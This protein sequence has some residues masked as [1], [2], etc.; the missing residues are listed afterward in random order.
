MPWLNLSGFVH[1][2]AE[3]DCPFSSDLDPC[4]RGNGGCDHR[5]VNYGGRPVCQC[6]PGY[7]LLGDRRMCEGIHQILD[8]FMTDES[9]CPGSLDSLVE[10]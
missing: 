6:N 1:G 5:C 10:A 2:I 4:N 8:I 3:P 9:L 7:R